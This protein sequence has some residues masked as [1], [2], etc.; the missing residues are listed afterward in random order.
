MREYV[1]KIWYRIIPLNRILSGEFTNL[2]LIEDFARYYAHDGIE[3]LYN[4]MCNELEDNLWGISDEGKREIANFY[5]AD[6]H[7][8]MTG[9]YNRLTEL[10]DRVRGLGLDESVVDDVIKVAEAVNDNTIRLGDLDNLIERYYTP[11]DR[12]Q[13]REAG[14]LP[15][16]P[17]SEQIN[18]FKDYFVAKFVGM[19]NN[20]DK[21]ADYVIPALKRQRT[22]K[23]MAAFALALYNSA[24]LIKHKRPNT[25]SR[26]LG[27]MSDIFNIPQILQY[28]RPSKWP[29]PNYDVEYH[30]LTARSKVLK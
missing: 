4:D 17:T 16:I 25:F 6:L 26:W 3:K 15:I 22:F 2:K 10:A 14:K 20:Q 27:V 30:Y 18:D 9:Y 23:D 1:N 13:Q 24:E 21:F 12:P 11:K 5:Y 28:N 8:L 19:G 7:P 29:Q